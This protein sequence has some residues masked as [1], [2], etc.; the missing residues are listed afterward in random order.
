M[1]APSPQLFASQPEA[2]RKAVL[3]DG[4]RLN[5]TYV[6]N[7][8]R[9]LIVA[10]LGYCDYSCNSCGQACPTGAIPPLHIGVKRQV[11]MGLARVDTNTCLPFRQ[12]DRRECDV[13]CV[14]C[15][16]AGYDAIEMREIEIPPGEPGAWSLSAAA[17]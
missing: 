9:R 10:R 17:P 5:S 11:H 14:E 13:C 7:R 8:S 16:Q 12:A 1:A 2:Y 4:D 15:R 3:S 6:T